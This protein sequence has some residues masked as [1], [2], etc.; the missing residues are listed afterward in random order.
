MQINEC[1]RSLQVCVK[2]YL[3]VKY[4]KNKCLQNI[5]KK[6]WLKI[7]LEVSHKYQK[8]LLRLHEEISKHQEI[9]FKYIKW[10][11]TSG[12]NEREVKVLRAEKNHCLNYE[13]DEISISGH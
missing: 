10:I 9:M 5:D 3:N 13:V 11:N 2:E 12:E 1:F 8:E 6:S 7:L 4:D